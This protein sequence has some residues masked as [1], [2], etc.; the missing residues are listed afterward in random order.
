MKPRRDDRLKRLRA[1]WPGVVGPQA[2][3]RTRLVA[4]DQGVLSVDVASAALK[5]DLATFRREEI[6]AALQERLEGARIKAVRY[7]VS[8]LS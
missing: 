4:F 3:E 1:A 5:H 8:D 7:R 2:A 6:L